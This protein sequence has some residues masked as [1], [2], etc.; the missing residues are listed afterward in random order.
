MSVAGKSGADAVITT[1]G[2]VDLPEPRYLCVA[3][4]LALVVLRRA[5]AS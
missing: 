1:F 4:L 5:T 3:G 2:T